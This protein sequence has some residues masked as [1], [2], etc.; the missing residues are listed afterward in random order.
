MGFLYCTT[1]GGIENAI[2]LTIAWY[3]DDPFC[4]IKND[5][6]L[7][8]YVRDICLADMEAN[9]S[10]ETIMKCRSRKIVNEIIPLIKT[11]SEKRLRGEK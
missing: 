1:D 3:Q 9:S 11:I 2:L 8:E 6:E 4:P 10:K 7:F 5:K